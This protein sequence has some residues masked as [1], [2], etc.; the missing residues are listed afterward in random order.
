M[1]AHLTR[2]KAR[3]AIHAHR[4]VLGLLEGEYAS[5]HTGRCMDLN[6]LREYVRGDDVKDLEWK[7]SAR[8]GTLLVKRFVAA[9]KHTVLL[10][11]STGRSMAAVNDVDV[12][13]RDLAVFVAGV[14]GW[15]AV[16][17]GDFVA[18]AYGDAAGQRYLAPSGGELGLERALAGVHDATRPDAAAADLEAVLRSS[19][20]PSAGAP[21]WWSSAT[22]TPSTPGSPR[23]CAG[24]RCSTRCCS[25]RSATSTRPTAPRP[26]AGRR[27]LRAGGARVGAGRPALRRE[28]AAR[29]RPTRRDPA[30]ARRA[31]HRPR[32]RERRRQRVAAVF[33]LLERHRHARRR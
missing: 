15:L 30:R 9:R 28:F 18:A 12:P 10:A 22:S 29:S 6:D 4:K 32:A 21:S 33:R 31:R 11:V 26:A 25:S 8:S 20:A 14:V 17:H 3:L 7:A 19:P 13:K 23:R 2:V 24:S 27:R 5:T 16:R 1:T